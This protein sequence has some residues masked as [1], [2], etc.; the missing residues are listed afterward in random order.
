MLCQPLTIPGVAARLADEGVPV[1]AIA[2]AL[3]L[4]YADIS[5]VLHDELAQGRIIELPK[6]DWPPG[7][8]IRSHIPTIAITHKTSSDE[9]AIA[10]RKMFKLTNLEAGFIV[11][12]LKIEHVTKEK[13][14]NV[15]ETQRAARASRPDDMEMTDQKMVDV[16]I[17]KLRKKLKVIDPEFIISTVWAGG[18][19]IDRAVK[20]KFYAYL[21]TEGIRPTSLLDPVPDVHAGD[22]DGHVVGREHRAK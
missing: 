7:V 12:L 11:L 16:I 17:C 20:E 6:P 21:V 8:T 2:R 14:H 4:P 10:C 3:G 15:I 18:Y 5:N 13:L 1:A 9:I 22:S 19:Y